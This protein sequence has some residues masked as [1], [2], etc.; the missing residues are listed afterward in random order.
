MLVATIVLGALWFVVDRRIATHELKKARTFLRQRRDVE[1][2]QALNRY[3][4]TFPG[5]DD[6]VLMWAQAVV[7]G[8][9]RTPEDAA[10]LA[11]QKLETI[12][13]QSP[14]AAEA[15][16][17]EGRLALLI[18]K[19]ATKAEQRLQRSA[20]L[21]PGIL[22]THYLLWK[23]FDMTERFQ[24]SE[25]HFWNTL[26]LTPQAG[27]AERLREWYV[28]Q[29]SPSAANAAL[30]R[31]MGFLKPGNLPGEQSDI[32]RL[33]EFFSSEPESPMVVAAL[34]QWHLRNR[35]REEAMAIL[36]E[37]AE[38]A[39]AKNNSFFLST[40]ISALIETGELEAAKQQFLF[41]PKGQ[42]GY[43]Y[44]VTAGRI[45]DLIDRDNKAA[46]LA[47]DEALKIWPGPVDWSTMHR[48]SQCSARMGERDRASEER[49]RSKKI[50]LLM[51]PEVHQRL[52]NAL[53]DLN[54]QDTAL[55][56]IDFYNQLDRKGEAEEWQKVLDELR[57]G[58]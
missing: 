54:S 32:A 37:I 24:F 48:K 26:K 23:L 1:A 29:F 47:Y 10:G 40:F 16:M 20:Q 22:D 8:D 57:Q 42:S 2:E 56:M 33:E 53:A 46:G 4:R 27:K 35:K 50:E 34:A 31:H 5:D 15:R 28:S 14:R 7:S 44:W 43:D 12:P 21:D 25:P 3:L 51:E 9:Q 38:K 13:D 41:W 18:L 30:D 45:S 49:A 17:R 39:E 11:I 58:Q 55:Q 6:A 36:N 52:R 19:Q